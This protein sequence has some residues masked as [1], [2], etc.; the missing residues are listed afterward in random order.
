MMEELLCSSWVRGVK[1]VCVSRQPLSPLERSSRALYHDPQLMSSKRRL[2]RSVLG[3]GTLKR[4][5]LTQA[6]QCSAPT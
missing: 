2:V 1:Y 5:A 6:L 3:G 4:A